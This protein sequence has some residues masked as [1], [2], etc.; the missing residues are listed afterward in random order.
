MKNLILLYLVLIVAFSCKSPEGDVVTHVTINDEKIPVIHFDN[1]TGGI[2]EIG[3]SEIVSDFKI[4]PLE[5][6]DECLIGSIQNYTF[7]DDKVMV[8]TQRFPGPAPAYMFNMEGKFVCELG[9]GGSGPGEHTGYTVVSIRATDTIQINFQDQIHLF[10]RNGK[11]IDDVK[12]PY[13]LMNDAYCYSG[14]TFFSLGSIT[15]YPTYQRDSVMIVFHDIDGRI[16]KTIPR[17]AYPPEPEKGFT[18]TG[19]SSSLYRYD[20]F[21]NVYMS[22]VDTLFRVKNLSL[23][24]R[25]VLDLGEKRQRYNEVMDPVKLVG[26]YTFY[27]AAENDNQWIFKNA[28]ITKAEVNEYQPGRWGG[29][30]DAKR[31]LVIISKKGGDARKVRLKDDIWAL[32]DDRRLNDWS[33]IVDN[34]KLVYSLQASDIK[35]SIA[36]RLKESDLDPDIRKRL[37][38]LDGRITE[39]SNPVIFIYYLKEKIR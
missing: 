26:L 2:E 3:I 17:Q 27:V 16:V 32:S 11:F 1:I 4:I 9:Q 7:I 23:Q 19:G 21:W 13:D 34:D 14:E 33:A 39:E 38:D 31:E 6:N 22:S 25:V 30:Y 20:G 35:I 15:G 28:E 37:E 24:P 18:P 8:S 10:D 12:Q 5:T 36:D 29:R